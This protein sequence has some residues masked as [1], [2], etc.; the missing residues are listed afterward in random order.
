MAVDRQHGQLP[1]A[2]LRQP[3]RDPERAVGADRAVVGDHDLPEHDSLRYLSNARSRRN[4]AISGKK[5]SAT[6]TPSSMMTNGGVPR[7]TSM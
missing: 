5:I 1:V 7:T 4:S 3:H 6:E 2:Q